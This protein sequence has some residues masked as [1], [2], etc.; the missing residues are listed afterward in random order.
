VRDDAT[1]SLADGA[2][3]LVALRR[4][5]WIVPLLFALALVTLA[6]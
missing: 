2:V 4:S 6:L 3:L 5:T 1:S